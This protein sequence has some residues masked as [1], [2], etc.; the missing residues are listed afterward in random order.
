MKKIVLL[1][2]SFVLAFTAHSQ[3]WESIDT[4]V[5]SNLILFDIDFP[6]G[7][8]DIGYTGGSSSTFNGEGTILKTEDAGLTW[9]VVYENTDSGTGVTALHF[10]NSS[11]G[12]AGTAS[13]DLL[14][15][16]NGGT[17]WAPFDPDPNNDQGEIRALEFN[18]DLVGV[19]ITAWEG[20]YYTQD[21]GF[22][23]TQASENYV[24]GQDI[25]YASNSNL[26]ACGNDQKIFSSTDGGDTWTE[27]FQ[28][29]NGAM[30]W[31]NLGISFFDDQNGLVTSEDGQYFHTTDGGANW[32]VGSIPDQ[33]GLMRGV[34]F[35]SADD[36]HVCATP[37]A[38]YKTTDGG[39]MWSLDSPLDVDP[40]YYEIIFAADGTGYVCGSGSTGGTIL[41]K[42]T[43]VDNIAEFERQPLSVFPVPC[44]NKL[45][46]SLPLDA[47]TALTVE[48]RNLHGQIVTSQ[49]E[50]RTFD[51]ASGQF[52]VNVQS[53]A[54][55]LYTIT[56]TSNNTL[57]TAQ[58]VKE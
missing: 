41:R 3:T 17:S 29:P 45:T 57:Y 15:T 34:H 51:N 24:G 1:T 30:M 56:L 31:V 55:G 33:F 11:L 43:V 53:L 7:Q 16:S 36:I 22:T 9:T 2:L 38:V 21:A 37:G 58:F 46:V 47:A 19:M 26:F 52:S 18:N 6:S 54:Q 13:G 14:F 39:Q 5:N 23:W 42:A 49:T 8:S 48:V 12:I 28:G 40:S 27:N 35:D 44:Q 32:S 25:T 4:P 10:F 50:S 20:V